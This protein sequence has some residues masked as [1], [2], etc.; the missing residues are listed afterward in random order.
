MGFSVGLLDN[1]IAAI[2]TELQDIKELLGI[3]SEDANDRLDRIH[4]V[5]SHKRAGSDDSVT[6]L[7]H[8]ADRPTAVVDGDIPNNFTRHAPLSD[9][10]DGFRS[11]LGGGKPDDTD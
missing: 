4:T 7:R 6:A 10:Y 11:R 3:A 1:A 9:P 2:F 5:L 8:R